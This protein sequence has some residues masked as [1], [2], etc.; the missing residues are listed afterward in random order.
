MY[1]LTNRYSL[2]TTTLQKGL[3]FM[4]KVAFPQLFYIG[5]SVQAVSEVAYYSNIKRLWLIYIRF[6]VIS[7]IP[8]QKNAKEK[9]VI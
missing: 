5:P 8:S 7:L 6:S 9:P 4:L 3:L 1:A 2:F